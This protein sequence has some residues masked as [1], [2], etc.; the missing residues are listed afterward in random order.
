V[1]LGCADERDL[2]F[3]DDRVAREAGRPQVH[4]TVT[5]GDPPRLWHWPSPTSSASCARCFTC[6]RCLIGT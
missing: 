3:L 5:Y 6:R 1:L 2:A 4:G